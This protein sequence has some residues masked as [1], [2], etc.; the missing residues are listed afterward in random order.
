V[1]YAGL[2]SRAPRLWLALTLCAP[3]CGGHDDAHGPVGELAADEYFY[4]C[5][6]PARPGNLPAFATDEAFREFV[7]K[8]AAAPP[9]VSDTQGPRLTAPMPPTKLSAASPPTLQFA[10]MQSAAASRPAP[11]PP[12][13]AARWPGLRAWLSSVVEGTAHAH[14]AAVSGDLFLLR[15]IDRDTTIYTALSGLPSFTPG[16]AAWKKALDG[17]IDHGITVTIERATFSTGSITNG[18]YVAASAPTFSVGP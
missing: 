8:D 16:A 9:T 1:W 11:A 15:L 2:M 10:V 18:P 12:R 7:N 17:R 3:G 14:C 6:D 13:R 5:Q 4:D